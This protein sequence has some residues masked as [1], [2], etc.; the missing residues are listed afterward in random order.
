MDLLGRFQMNARLLSLIVQSKEACRLLQQVTNILEPFSK[1]WQPS[2]LAH[3]D[4]YDDQLL[5]TPEGNLALVDFEE[6]GP[7]DPLLDVG[8]LL[9]HLRRAA[10]FGNSQ[11]ACDTYRRLVRSEALARFGWEPQALALREAIALFLLTPGPFRQ[12]QD[13][14]HGRVETGLALALEALQEA[15]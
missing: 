9:A 7:G 3:N 10:R 12:L 5:L 2:A 4:F 8:K 1:A 15:P 13:D 14:W 11:E 6:I